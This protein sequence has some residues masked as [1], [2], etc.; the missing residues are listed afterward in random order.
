MV[1]STPD[2]HQ[3]RQPISRFAS[4]DVA[5]A[6]RRFLFLFSDTGGGHRASAQ[7]VKDEMNRLYGSRVTVEMLDLFVELGQWPFDR[8]PGWYPACVGLNGI[9]WGLGFHLSD[10]VPLVGAMSR[11]VWPYV[12]SSLCGFLL[13]HPTDVIASFHPIPNSALFLALHHLHWQ[14]PVA[15]VTL[16]MVTAHAGWFAPGAELYSVPTDAAKERALRWGLEEDRIIVTGMPTRRGFLAAVDFTKAEARAKLGLAEDKPM[17]LIVGGGEGMGPVAQVVRAIVRYRPNALLVVITGRN[18]ALYEDL[19]G[20]TAPMPIHVKGFVSDME[21]WMRAADILVTKA[22]P[23]TISEASIA[24]L[25]MV[26]Y[27]ALPGQEQGNIEYVTKN[28]AGFWAPLPRQVARAVI[29][30]LEDPLALKAMAA[31]AR[32][33]ARPIATE[34]IAR[35]LWVLAKKC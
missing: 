11:F 4:V 28:G 25:P 20:I 10:R 33:L 5:D 22:G 9:P 3:T 6:P 31:R 26:L 18:H 24:G 8:F 15:I 14:V 17:V 35:S 1:S 21:V 16:D 32:S 7:A 29:Q 2:L 34:Q 30:L 13:R 23:N 19:L 27:A 12:R